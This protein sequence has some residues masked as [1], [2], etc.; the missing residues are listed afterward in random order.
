MKNVKNME[1]SRC[2][3]IALLHQH[4]YR[5]TEKMVENPSQYSQFLNWDSQRLSLEQKATATPLHP[6]DFYNTSL[7]RL[8]VMWQYIPHDIKFSIMFFIKIRYFELAT[9]QLKLLT[10]LTN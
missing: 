7:V 9:E 1:G 6:F 5:S 2:G 3:V 4:S 8:K 10:T